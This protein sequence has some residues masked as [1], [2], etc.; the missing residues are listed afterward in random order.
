MRLPVV[1]DNNR[2]K[3]V[4]YSFLHQASKRGDESHVLIQD[5]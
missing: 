3:N 1:N 4:L 5:V 2:E